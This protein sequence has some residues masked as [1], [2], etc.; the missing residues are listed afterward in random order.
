MS[1][2]RILSADVINRIAA[3][4]VVE[5]PASVVKELVENS[6]DAG[7]GRIECL[8]EKGG[9]E[10]IEVSDDG[11]GMD[12]ED[13]AV[14][15]RRHATSKISEAED[16]AAIATLGFRGEALS[17][18]A[19]VSRLR[20]VSRPR[21]ASSGYWLEVEGGRVTGSGE[22]GA[23]PGSQVR[24]ADLF[25]NTPARRK[26]LRTV[27][28]EMGHV[29]GWLQRLAL[30][31]PR[32]HLVLRHGRRTVLDI[33]PAGD[34]TQRVAAVLGR[35]VF[36]HLYPVQAQGE[37]MTVNGL[38][39]DPYETR[40]G[41]RDIHFVV[42]GRYVRDRLLQQAVVQSARSVLPGGRLPVAVLVLQ[43]EP[44]LVDVNVHPQKTE[45]RFLSPAAVRQLVQGA[46]AAHWAAAP[47]LPGT[48]RY[49]L[50][51]AAPAPAAAG[52]AVS[53]H[54]SGYR[55]GGHPQAPPRPP[56]AAPL[57]GEVPPPAPAATAAA[58]A[59][60]STAG[61]MGQSLSL[62]QWHLAG[63]L[64]RTYLLLTSADRLVVV[65][66]HAAAERIT[67]EKLRRQ[68]DGN[69]VAVQRLLVP[70]QVELDERLYQRA[71]EQSRQL[72]ELGFE[73]EPF[74]AH[75]VNVTG[76]P[77]LLGDCRVRQLLRDTLEE[78]EELAPGAS[79]RQARDSVLGRMA[80]HASVRA[81]QEL[82]EPQ[83]RALL[84]QLEQV[85]HGGTCPHG[86]PVLVE[87]TRQQVGGW[88]GRS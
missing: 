55:H 25:F 5:R 70:V 78:L 53:D 81:G 69:R 28:T 24:V 40:S 52:G 60:A 15:V 88:F 22:I 58:A 2:V 30:A 63:V 75:T 11:Q 13:L 51:A 35:Q 7:A 44:H 72:A 86:R 54:R 65:D 4:E 38:V 84:E 50:A 32:V 74:G 76:I 45:V 17:S 14:A 62:N 27:A 18:I 41:A 21:G 47:W 23:P 79:W 61:E 34:F 33:A 29:Q 10:L 43:M 77:A 19:A 57:T 56:V 49:R 82:A 48:R 9:R 8:V 66:Q 26:F 20:L 6:L 87:F 71:Q 59:P 1:K 73:L 31:R 80:C 12:P 46:L 36:E 83:V 64:W 37:G 3:G 67:F 39:G 16:L 85:D 68:A 42:N